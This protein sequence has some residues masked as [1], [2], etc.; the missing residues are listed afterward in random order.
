MFWEVLVA[1]CLFASL[2]WLIFPPLPTLRV[3]FANLMEINPEP[4]ALAGTTY[5]S[6]LAP[7]PSVCARVWGLLWIWAG[8]TKPVGNQT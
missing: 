6:N 3:G 8:F 5:F 2:P 4:S 7:E 1:L